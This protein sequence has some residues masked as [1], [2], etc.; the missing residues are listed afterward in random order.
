MVNLDEL[1][2]FYRDYGESSFAEDEPLYAAICHG[3]A[4][5]T[6]LL[7][8]LAAHVQEA[9]QP[10][11][12]LAA[13]HYLLLGG[14][15]HELGAIYSGEATGDVAAA[16]ADLVLG[17]RSEVD[18][19][20]ETRRTQTNEVGRSAMLAVMLQH[21]AMQVGDP[22]A[23][24]DLGT[25]GGLNLLLDQFRINYEV[26]GAISS[27][28]PAESPVVI[29]CH[30]RSGHPDIEPHCPEI[31]WRV[32]VDQAPVDVTDPAE[33]RWLQACLWPS[34]IDR[35]QRMAAAIDIAKQQ[36][37]EII[38]ADAADGL[39]Q[40]LA[41]APTDHEL[42]LTTT[43]VWFYLPQVTRQ[44]VLDTLRSSER[45]V[46]WYSC[47]GAG[48]VAELNEPAGRQ[49]TESTLGLVELGGARSQRSEVLGMSHPHGVWFTWNR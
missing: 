37:P 22:L 32:G 14:V 1:G 26:D 36:P 41:A 34:K 4:D 47:E 40:A 5:R 25:S 12:I 48:V 24:I 49:Y 21:A 19:L 42:V 31:G 43:W 30:V 7:E 9:Q 18:H 35:S 23:W 15:E 13:A 33:A 29:D 38:S 11:L 20:L 10:N 28:G 44:L 2:D 46:R 16:F 45:R 39:V 27:T 6:Q 8:L 3:I 17:H